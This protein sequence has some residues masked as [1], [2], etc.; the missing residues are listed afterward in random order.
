MAG[1]LTGAQCASLFTSSA[2]QAGATYCVGY[3][4]SVVCSTYEENTPWTSSSYD[5]DSRAV[6]LEL[7]NSSS[8]GDWPIGD[9]TMDK[10]VLMSADIGKRNNIPSPLT[11]KGSFTWHQMFAATSCPGPWFLA[12][13]DSIIDWIAKEYAGPV[14]VLPPPVQMVNEY[15]VCRGDSL[16]AIGQKFG[17][18]W[19]D[20]AAANGIVSPYIIYTGQVL[21]IP[22]V[23]EPSPQPTPQPI[24][25]P[26]P[27][28][29]SY[30][31]DAIAREVIRGD[32]GNGEARKLALNSAG[33]DYSVVQMRVNAILSGKVET[34]APTPVPP[35]TG[36]TVEQL[37]R[38]VIRGEWGVGQDRINRL[39]AAG[40]DA[41]AVQRRVN[42]M[43]S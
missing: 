39:T 20:I 3:D 22:G 26:E 7:S 23:A 1:V 6:T 24:P 21:F 14:V 17:V 41:A 8:G 15:I 36:K 37:A 19:G 32:W 18:S 30:D 42:E 28:K 10:F 5:N 40:Y 12:R 43:L 25:V 38:E 16:W 33:Y 4:A 29:P 31:V 34:P 13:I 27:V 9:R 2:R 11:K 35:S